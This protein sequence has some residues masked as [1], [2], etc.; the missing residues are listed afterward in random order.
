VNNA[1]HEFAF[2]CSRAASSLVIFCR[3]CPCFAISAKQFHDT[4]VYIIS[5]HFHK[6]KSSVCLGFLQVVSKRTQPLLRSAITPALSKPM[7]SSSGLG[8]EVGSADGSPDGCAD[9]CPV[10]CPEGCSEGCP[11]VVQMAALS[12]S[13]RLTPPR[14]HLISPCLVLISAVIDQSLLCPF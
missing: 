8:A 2:L 14:C 1:S 6:S 9:G 10:G 7:D 12:R 11:D 3:R 4:F 5:P 13:D